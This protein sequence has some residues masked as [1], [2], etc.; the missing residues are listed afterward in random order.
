[1]P[2]C[3]MGRFGT[4]ENMYI[5]T[6]YGAISVEWSE[7]C[8]QNPSRTLPRKCTATAEAMNVQR[9]RNCGAKR[10]INMV[11]AQTKNKSHYLAG[12]PARA[13]EAPRY[14]GT[15]RAILV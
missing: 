13:K 8:R 3:K 7:T 9:S 10:R 6:L 12:S 15:Q 4:A 1:M 11:E 14:E 2:T 5:S